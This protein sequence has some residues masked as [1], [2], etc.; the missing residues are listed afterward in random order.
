MAFNTFPL[1][2]A[3]HSI[4]TLLWSLFF[5]F[6][7]FSPFF[8]PALVFIPNIF[9]HWHQITQ[10]AVHIDLATVWKADLIL[11]GEIGLSEEGHLL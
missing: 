10:E 3:F 8:L 6:L 5:S 7:L 1:Y 9:L 4:L 11:S 2:S